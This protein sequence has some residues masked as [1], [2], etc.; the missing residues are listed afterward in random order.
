MTVDIGFS[1][2][3]SVVSNPPLVFS[4][5]VVATAYG[6]DS[7]NVGV[8]QVGNV[9]KTVSPVGVAPHAPPE[10]Y[11][12]RPATVVFSAPVPTKPSVQFGLPV[13]VIAAVGYD[14]LTYGAPVVS[15]VAQG[16]FTSGDDY[17]RVGSPFIG[18]PTQIEFNYSVPSTADVNFGGE[19]TIRPWGW[20]NGRY[21][22]PGVY[23]SLRRIYVSGTPSS[24]AFGTAVLLKDQQVSPVAVAPGACGTPTVS[25]YYRSLL[26]HGAAH[27]LSG[28]P[29]VQLGRRYVGPVYV[30]TTLTDYGTP[31]VDWGTRYITPVSVAAP[32][33]GTPEVKD[34]AARIRPVG[35]ENISAFGVPA[36][37]D[38]AQTVYVHGA[39]QTTVERAQVV[40]NPQP[41]YAKGYLNHDPES[42]RFSPYT[43]IYN[44][45]RTVRPNGADSF[46]FSLGASVLNTARVVAPPGVNLWTPGASFVTHGIQRVLPPGIQPGAVS[47]YNALRNRPMINLNGCGINATKVS[48]PLRVWSNLQTVRAVSAASA[49]QFGKAWVAASPRTLHPT[50]PELP[51]PSTHF[52]APRVRT[53][54]PVGVSS[55]VGLPAL[56]T[57]WNRAKAWGYVHSLYGTATVRN[58][59][60]E[61]R[62]NSAV[63]QLMGTPT[64]NLYTRRV[65]PEGNRH[66][67][68]GDHYVSYRTR[69]I[70][71]KGLAPPPI[72]NPTVTFDASQQTP[73][74]QYIVSVNADTHVGY[75]TP[76]LRN[77]ALYPSGVECT[78]YGSHELQSMAIYDIKSVDSVIEPGTPL[79]LGGL[80]YIRASSAGDSF[81]SQRQA[82][83]GLQLI[84]LGRAWF[85]GP[86]PV[87]EKADYHT[88]G[89]QY[90]WKEQTVGPVVGRV[91][92]TLQHRR[93]MV[94]STGVSE[95]DQKP[96]VSFR[97]QY[98]YPTGASTFKRGTPDVMSPKDVPL[99]TYGQE[100][101]L[102]GR[103][104]LVQPYTGP[105]WVFPSSPELST[106]GRTGV[107]NR[108][109]YVYVNGFDMSLVKNPQYIGPYQWLY[110]KGDTTDLHGTAYVDYGVR[111]VTQLDVTDDMPDSEI[112]VK[113][114]PRAYFIA[115]KPSSAKYG[116]H[117]VSTPP[118]VISADGW[119]EFQTGFSYVPRFYPGSSKLRSQAFVASP[120]HNSMETGHATI[121]NRV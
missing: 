62:P 46:R 32:V 35:W 53:L 48:L 80:Q 31:M 77:N 41:I 24:N 8:A 22:I 84:D 117:H 3:G 29:Q 109:R 42:G 60:P 108:H 74:Q 107:M 67:A 45:D 114:A 54:R 97:K 93:V 28:T 49:N 110:A 33:P 75:G 63:T 111:T 66:I 88:Y 95:N 85:P 2:A 47:Q 61:I 86:P 27:Q 59:R 100:Q 25:N 38:S 34:R 69:V 119:E 15:N 21:G 43:D 83:I 104:R 51:A 103:A 112:R 14:E 30:P 87:W 115:G 6:S 40:H 36:V 99:E 106:I 116:Q 18:L 19:P 105:Q 37:H 76:V 102:F 57:R 12:G 16:V 121:F 70:R 20:D 78:T 65:Y 26:V 5:P 98:V 118:Q 73:P 1:T 82:I 39:V 91:E 55:Y 11:V 92:V 89:D 79:V 68:H 4:G 71:L 13:T 56:E 44:R 81:D 101:T 113:H 10:V 96:R 23:S 90:Q 9:S 52:V 94:N 64:V 58:L 120:A 7:L 50:A 17:T 72:L